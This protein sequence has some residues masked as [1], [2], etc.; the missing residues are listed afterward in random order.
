LADSLYVQQ[1]TAIATPG[2][3]KAIDRV[4]SGAFQAKI[5]KGLGL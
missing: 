1:E 4:F 2:A 5:K 3:L